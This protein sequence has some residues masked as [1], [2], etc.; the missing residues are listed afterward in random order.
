ML[1]VPLAPA[2]Q[3]G[4]TMGTAMRAR[5]LFVTFGQTNGVCQTS[6]RCTPL[7]AASWSKMAPISTNF[8][9][10][11]PVSCHAAAAEPLLRQ[12]MEREW[13]EPRHCAQSRKRSFK[14]ESWL[15]SP[16]SHPIPVPVL[17]SPHAP[18]RAM[19]TLWARPNSASVLRL[20][21][22]FMAAS[23][24]CSGVELRH[25]ST[26]RLAPHL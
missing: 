4:A 6:R 16:F 7:V 18:R 21:C 25:R 17:A 5:V 2:A 24:C 22:H 19:H 1:R 9:L 14:S 10:F 26:P 12:S 8:A 13:G 20:E 3:L 23:H 11:S 15:Q